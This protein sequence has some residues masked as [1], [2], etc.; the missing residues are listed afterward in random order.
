M[1]ADELNFSERVK[2]AI[3]HCSGTN[4]I[5]AIEDMT[6]ELTI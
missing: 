2:Q 5:D 4:V 1:G 3:L 6:Q